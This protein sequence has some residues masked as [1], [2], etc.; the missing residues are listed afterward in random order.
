MEEQGPS[1]DSPR[2]RDRRSARSVR[3][4]PGSEQV[5][6]SPL[7]ARV[8]QGSGL[9]RQVEG[10]DLPSFMQ[11]SG[12]LSLL[13]GTLDLAPWGT[14]SPST[15]PEVTVLSRSMGTGQTRQEAACPALKECALRA[16]PCLLPQG[17]P[18]WRGRKVTEGVV[19]AGIG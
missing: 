10:E 9:K 11:I 15:A 6:R 4:S 7:K 19:R 12:Q 5:P 18:M 1:T 3:I 2:L 14:V 8:L 16:A 13:K 17:D